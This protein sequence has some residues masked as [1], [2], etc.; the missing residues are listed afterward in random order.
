MSLRRFPPR[1]TRPR[2]AS[3]VLCAI[4][5]LAIA[6]A[7][8][9]AGRAADWTGILVPA[10]FG[11]SNPDWPRLADSAGQVPITAIANVF[12]GPG[13]SARDD[14][15]RV[16]GNVRASGGRVVGYVHTTYT[17]R[18]LDEVIQDMRRWAQFYPIDGIFVDE[19]TNDGAAAG[20]EYYGAL[21]AEARRLGS[22]WIVIGNPGAPTRESYLARPAADVLV[23]FENRTGYDSMSPD[24]WTRSHPA[25]A[26]GHLCYEV[27]SSEDMARYVQL[28]RNR[29][30]GW[31]YVTDD[32]APNPWDRLPSYWKA[33]VAAVRALNASV[34]VRVQANVHGPGSIRLQ[35]TSAPGR[36]VVETS[37]DLVRWQTLHTAPAPAGKAEVIL[38]TAGQSWRYLRAWR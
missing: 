23:T 9:F 3:A 14:Y 35:I 26:F 28:A 5:S 36:Y 1:F 16:I 13:T 31:I 22:D 8:Q 38:T 32:T 37:A 10:Y 21:L 33:E 30:A 6:L 12:N 4:A 19:M 7:L 18:A 29:R 25:S 17:R 20:L 11:P 24:L 2:A 34:P 27:S 15:N